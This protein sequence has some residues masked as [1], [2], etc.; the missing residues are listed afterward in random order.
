MSSNDEGRG[1]LA[2]FGAE[3]FVAS[4]INEYRPVYEM[5]GDVNDRCWSMQGIAGA[6]PRWPATQPAVAS[7]YLSCLCCAVD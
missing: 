1:V 5:C 4:D 2:N 6:P 3:R 7:P